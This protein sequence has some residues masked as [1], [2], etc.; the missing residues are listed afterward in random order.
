MIIIDAHCHLESEN[1]PE[2]MIE[3]MDANNVDQVVLFAATCENIPVIPEALFWLGGALLQTPL[4]PIVRTLFENAVSQNKGKVKSN[5]IL[6]DIYNEPD[7]NSVVGALN[8]YPERFI[9]FVFINPNASYDAVSELELQLKHPLMKGVKAH[10]WFH[11]FSPDKD[12][13]DIADICSNKGLPL[14][15]HIGSRQE[16][17][18]IKPLI[19]S[20]P[21]LKLIL[22]HLGFPW[23]KTAFDLANNFPNVYLDISG[24]YLSAPLVQKAVKQVGAH[25][26]IFGTDGPYGLRT[27]KPGTL[28]Y[29]KPLSWVE[30]LQI[31]IAEK[32]M[33]LSKNLLGL[34]P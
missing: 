19:Q 27:E 3:T 30:A 18:S 1:P 32:E 25:K 10:S 4:S 21:N 28:S 7:N 11:N 26:L 14:L 33:I 5:G 9:G 17:A 20:F 2:K 23:F 6:Y 31:P 22:A 24:P 16:T 13:M 34:L 8:L 12:L 29:Q 15:I